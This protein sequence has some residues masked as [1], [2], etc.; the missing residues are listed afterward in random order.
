MYRKSIDYS[1]VTYVVVCDV[2]VCARCALF[3]S[4]VYHTCVHICVCGLLLGF[5][6]KSYCD[7]EKKKRDMC[8]YV[9]GALRG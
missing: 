3:V 9:R 2:R 1:C 8:V 4:A 7:T 6:K 5:A